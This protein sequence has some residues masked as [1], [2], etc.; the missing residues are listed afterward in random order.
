MEQQFLQ[1]I[2]ELAQKD[3]REAIKQAGEM[4][5]PDMKA[6]A[7]ATVVEAV[8]EKDPETARTVMTRAIELL[9]DLQRP[10]T[11]LTV[12][13]ATADDNLRKVL[14][15]QLEQQLI[16]GFF[17]SIDRF[18]KR[19]LDPDL[20]NLSDRDVWP[21]TQLVRALMMGIGAEQA[22]TAAPLL[23][24]IKDLDLRLIAQAALVR[25]L[26]GEQLHSLNMNFST[27]DGKLPPN[28]F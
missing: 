18:L 12:V 13:M 11:V 9:P 19:D 23:E 17:K 15:P 5:D 14:T 22:D 6:R 16:E 26:L 21:S 1:R 7:L 4:K 20:P 3:P 28:V 27:K 2:A 10:M 25:G 24:Q 8:G